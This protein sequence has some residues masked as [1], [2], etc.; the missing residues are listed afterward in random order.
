MI[1]EMTA[2]PIQNS[3]YRVL[4]AIP[5]THASAGQ[6]IHAEL[7]PGTIFTVTGPAYTNQYEMEA[8]PAKGKLG[9]TEMTFIIYAF[10]FTNTNVEKLNGGGHRKSRRRKNRKARKSRRSRR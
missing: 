3:Q 4:T 1:Y 7:T 5:V 8:V 6:D 9:N 10:E 2:V